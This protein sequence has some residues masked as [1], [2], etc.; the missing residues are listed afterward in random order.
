[1]EIQKASGIQELEECAKMMSESEPWITLQRK[2][3]AVM[4]ILQDTTSEVYIAV[5]ENIITGCVVIKMQGPFTGY[6][7]SIVINPEY[8]SKGIGSK[9]LEF[10]E[11]RVF[12]EKPNLFLCVSSFNPRAQKLYENCGFSVIGELKDYIVKGYSEIL[13]RKT[14]APISDY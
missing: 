12:S 3:D 13:M 9:L 2:F 6:L 5:S 11:N 4:S 10:T 8:R 14:I 1:M 7:Q